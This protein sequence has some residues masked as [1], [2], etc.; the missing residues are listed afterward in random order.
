MQ[1]SS[2]IFLVLLGVWAAYFVLYWVRRRDNLVTART[3]DQLSDSMRVLERRSPAAS[4]EPAARSY[5]ASPIRAVP[6]GPRVAA[7]PDERPRVGAM[8]PGRRVRGL[9]LLTGLVATLAA[10]PAAGFGVLPWLA[11]L[12]PT[13]LVGIGVGWLRA[14]VR[15]EARARRLS[16]EA[17]RIVRDPVTTS[18]SIRLAGSA[19]LRTDSSLAA[20]AP[21]RTGATE[22]AERTDHAA[23]PAAAGPGDGVAAPAQQSEPVLLEP[24]PAAPLVDEDDI[25]LTWDP[26]PVP[27]PT[28]AMKA[29]A[30]RPAP[31]PAETTPAPEPVRLDDAAYGEPE[32]RVAGA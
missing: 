2:V 30:E 5:A 7:E 29:K 25:P 23:P 27:R 22:T 4:A 16:A 24:E 20:E 9:T 26:I 10:I 15:G 3:A 12:A 31:P 17:R 21:D 1:P 19:T 13:A 8:R 14:G 28:Y 18:G 32:R 6:G 11:V